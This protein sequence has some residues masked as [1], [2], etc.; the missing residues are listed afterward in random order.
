MVDVSGMREGKR[1]GRARKIFFSSLVKHR[2]ARGEG[3]VFAVAEPRCS[4]GHGM[5]SLS[6]LQP[7][8]PLPTMEAPAIPP[9]LGLSLECMQGTFGEKKGTFPV[10]QKNSFDCLRNRC[11]SL[12]ISHE[13]PTQCAHPDRCRQG[14]QKA[15]KY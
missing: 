1:K 10:L 15:L 13:K 9:G 3:G 2:M 14:E 12:I 8:G 7:Q 11:I 5:S 6:S 4:S